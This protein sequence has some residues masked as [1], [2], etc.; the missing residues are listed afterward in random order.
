MADGQKTITSDNV[1]GGNFVETNKLLKNPKKKTFVC[2]FSSS[3][4]NYVKYNAR[5]KDKGLRTRP[6]GPRATLY[7]SDSGAK[8]SRP[9]FIV[10]GGPECMHEIPCDGMSG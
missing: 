8:K 9:P 10:H 4:F 1:R 2:F 5:F 7:N 6:I 3:T